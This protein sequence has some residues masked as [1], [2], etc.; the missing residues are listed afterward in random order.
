MVKITSL[1]LENIKRIKAVKLEPKA[2][3][4]TIIGGK[5]GQGK[6]SAL[7]AI[8]WVLGGNKYKPSMAN[9]VGSMLPPHLKV[10]LSNG[11]IA[12][13]KGTNSDLKVYDPSG[14]TQGAQ[15]L[16]NSF[17]SEFSLDLPS[18]MASSNKE[19]AQILLKLAGVESQLKELAEKEAQLY[20]ERRFVGQEAVKK[21]GY[22][23]ELPFYP[24]APNE[25]ISAYEITQQMTQ[26]LAKNA[27]NQRKRNQVASL[28]RDRDD[29]GAELRRLTE[30]IAELEAQ[31]KSTL[32]RLESC[33]EAVAIAKKSAMDLEDE[34][35]EELERS[36][37]EID[38]I[39][40]QVKA[41]KE[42][43]RAFQEAQ[44]LGEVYDEKSAE[45]EDVRSARMKLLDNVKF[46]LE[47]LTLSEDNALLYHGQEWDN[48]SGSEQLIVAT[49]IT[50]QLSP[51]C[52][53]VL[54]DKLEQM[55][56]DTLQ[57]FG[58]W[59]ESQDL[60]V[61]ATRVSQGGECQV[62]IEDG[63]GV[64]NEEKEDDEF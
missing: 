53:F 10:T 44:S 2:S 6:S 30:R 13:R 39:N 3:G 20:S 12:E 59:L 24:D 14:K 58:A 63:Y 57:E 19:K 49:A 16:L 35:T 52:Q 22:A 61:I 33:N 8:A 40:E 28:E 15:S 1:E 21:K 17:I 48:M 42:R 46:P 62:I 34:S 26:I 29:V 7:D 37:E 50:K 41:N 25:S 4:L 36:L 45:I 5:N 51:T 18:F 9:R 55:D 47:G 31:K 43:A 56:L 64:A 38:S 11:I 32:E 23:E 54:M 60:Q 27:E